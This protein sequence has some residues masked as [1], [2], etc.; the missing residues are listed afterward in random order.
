MEHN[1]EQIFAEQG[2]LAQTL[3]NYEYRLEQAEMAAEIYNCLLN[4]KHG[5]IEAGTGVGKSLA[6]LIP[7]IIYAKNNKRRIIVATN[8]INLQE[9]L[10]H[11]DI[12]LITKILSEEFQAAIFKGRSNYICLRRLQEAVL[13]VT[14]HLDI[15]RY[16]EHINQWVTTTTS[17]ERSDLNPA[18]PDQIWNN[19]CCQKENC[20]E[21]SCQFFKQC[22]YWQL[23]HSLSQTQVIV[24]NQA[25]LLADIVTDNSVLPKYDAVIIDEAHNLEDVA[26]SAFSHVLSSQ[27]MN[28]YYRAGLQLFFTLRPSEPA[29]KIEDFRNCLEQMINSSNEYFGSI[30]THV[31]CTI[32]AENRINFNHETLTQELK[33]I[34]KQLQ[35]FAPEDQE[36]SM[37]ISQYKEYTKNVANDVELILQTQDPDFV[38]WSELYGSDVVLQ[39][40]PISVGKSLNTSLFSTIKT[41]ILTSATLSTNNTFNYFK[42]RIGLDDAVELRLGSPFDY[43]NQALLCVP[44]QVQKPNH[45]DYNHF[46]AYYLLHVAARTKGGVLALFTSYQDMNEVAD[47]MD[48]KLTEVGYTL[49]VQGDESRTRL[50]E[51]FIT[52]DKA[53]LLGTN[54]FW[55]GI[56]IP[57]QNLRA[58]VITRLPFAV[59][60]RPVTAAR[61]KAIEDDGG[62]SFQEFSLP[63]AILRLKQ[64]FGRLIRSKSDQGAVVILDQRFLTARYGQEFRDSLPPARF[65][66][67]LDDL[68]MIKK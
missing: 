36:L 53:V 48:D 44:K 13:G 3:N 62:N 24:T 63:Q 45:P 14:P 50:T 37:L 40:A 5:I 35:E 19:I 60:D 51:Q 68:K 49:L 67:D 15:S 39:A 66:R 12:P 8:T 38:Y 43:A 54:S 21:E 41:V 30:N 1:V 57:G 2:I 32:T 20:P 6:Y 25:L 61:I 58:V 46:T 27:T 31:P 47:N 17:G 11:K 29:H 23:R 7:A 16:L 33:K 34:D 56:D 64:G 42:N 9:Q 10:F 52:T 28:I 18:L 55:E 22:F 65:T 26:T 59:P 4:E